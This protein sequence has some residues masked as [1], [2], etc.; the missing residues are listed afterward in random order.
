[1]QCIYRYILE[2]SEPWRLL[3]LSV[4]FSF[5]CV[6]PRSLCT[7]ILKF[8][9]LCEKNPIGYIFLGYIRTGIGYI[10]VAYIRVGYTFLDT[11]ILD[12]S[13]YIHIS[14]FH[15]MI[16]WFGYIHKKIYVN[17]IYP[18]ISLISMDISNPDISKTNIYVG[19][20]HGFK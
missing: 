2:T 20:I 8:L 12:I 4:T 3:N 18:D 13:G 19:Y 7:F 14:Y 6:T 9:I 15:K 11:S 5:G 16:Y 1:M 17:W 10:F